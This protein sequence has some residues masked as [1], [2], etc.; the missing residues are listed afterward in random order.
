MSPK[1]NKKTD[2]GVDIIG[3]ETPPTK[4]AVANCLRSDPVP[5][6]P[7][8]LQ[9]NDRE[10]LCLM[11]SDSFVNFSPILSVSLWRARTNEGL[12]NSATYS[13]DIFCIEKN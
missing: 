2:Y 3:A 4:G 6:N 7:S 1:T 8:A 5:T 13:D 9:T 11:L 10:R 12:C